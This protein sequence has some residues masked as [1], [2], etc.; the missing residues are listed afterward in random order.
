M[1][2]EKV[3]DPTERAYNYSGYLIT[4]VLYVASVV[5]YSYTGW[6]IAL[7]VIM[8]L[9]AWNTFLY[10]S[11]LGYVAH[12]MKVGVKIQTAVD[13]ELKDLAYILLTL[14]SFSAGIYQLYLAGYVFFAG[15]ASAV[16]LIRFFSLIL[17]A[18]HKGGIK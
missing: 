9:A 14:L 12:G 2:N 5:L 11:V 13:R 7:W 15:L 3:V 8:A 4:S 16:L 17:T 10:I 1:N 6:A 18:I